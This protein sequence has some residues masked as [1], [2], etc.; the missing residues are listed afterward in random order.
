MKVILLWLMICNYKWHWNSGTTKCWHTATH[1]GR[2]KVASMQHSHSQAYDNHIMKKTVY[3]KYFQA[4]HKKSN[5]RCFTHQNIYKIQIFISIKYQHKYYQIA[6]GLTK[7][8]FIISNCI[9][10]QPGVLHNY[11]SRHLQQLTHHNVSI[12]LELNNSS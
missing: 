7:I 2:V 6:N 8:V 4:K 9:Y 11:N 3:V 5:S 1:F 12:T 10:S